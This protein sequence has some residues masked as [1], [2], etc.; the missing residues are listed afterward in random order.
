MQPHSNVLSDLLSDLLG[1]DYHLLVL[2]LSDAIEL[3]E[4]EGAKE[5]A[6]KYRELR[7]KITGIGEVRKCII[8]GA[9]MVTSIIEPICFK[10]WRKEVE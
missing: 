10:C 4:R 7:R 9:E 2:A 3:A 8:C 1:D 6:K 5:Q